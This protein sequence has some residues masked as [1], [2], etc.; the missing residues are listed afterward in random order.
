MR[1]NIK[2]HLRTIPD[3]SI[4]ELSVQQRECCLICVVGT[5]MM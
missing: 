5:I 3:R 1:V 2:L 4:C